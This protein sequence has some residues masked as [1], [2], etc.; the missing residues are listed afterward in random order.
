MAATP[1]FIATLKTPSV[2]FVN[3]DSTNYK[4]VLA[5]GA[6]GTRIDTLFASNSDAANAYT[7]QLSIQVSGVDNVIG[8]VVVPLGAGTNGSAKSVALLN[9]ADI[10][11]LAYTEGGA[12][13]LANGAMLRARVKTSVAGA[14][15]VNISGVAGDY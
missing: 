14:N 11:G 4:T 15:S 3:A 12:L 10:P 7:L 6:L 2:A 8:E 1:Q 5:A 9:P 13:F